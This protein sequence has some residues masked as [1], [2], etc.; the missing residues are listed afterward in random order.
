M[1]GLHHTT[2]PESWKSIGGFTVS[3]RGRIRGKWRILNPKPSLD[4]YITV[5]SY[6][7]DGKFKRVY[8]HRLIL[9]AFVGPCPPGQECRHLDGNPSNNRLSN[10][11]W[12]THDENRSDQVRHGRANQG[13]RHGMS[14]FSE[15]DVIEIRRLAEAGVRRSEIALRFQA[16]QSAINKI[17]RR[18]LWKHI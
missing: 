3:D 15:T 11:A 7:G 8:V 16:H 2:A 14:R 12:G 10:L 9:E 13:I 6:L 17:C 1:S 5:A 18:A 4:G